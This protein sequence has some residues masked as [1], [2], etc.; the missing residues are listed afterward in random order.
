LAVSA[1][2]FG[3]SIDLNG[4]K[5]KSV[6][7]VGLP[8]AKSDLETNEI[9]R[10]YDEK[11]GKGK[12]YGYVIPAF[13]NILQNV[14]RCIRSEED[15]GAIIY[16]DERYAWPMYRNYFPKTIE[17]RGSRSYE[18]VKDFLNEKF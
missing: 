6:I 3:E 16:L 2:S 10:Y 18:D 12:D 13:T 11:F 14:G 9:I 4:D 1:G 15:K 7:V 17:L 8:F 5:L